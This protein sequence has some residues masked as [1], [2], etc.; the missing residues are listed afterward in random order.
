MYA[1]IRI[2]GSVGLRGDLEQTLR[3]LRLNR[4]NHCVLLKKDE[5]SEG[6]LR[7]VVGFITWGE[8]SNDTLK[9]LVAKRGRLPGD[10]R[11]DEKAAKAA[12]EAILKHKNM[13]EAVIKPVFRLSPP[14]KGIKSVRL[15]FPKGDSGY[16]GDKINELL[17]KMI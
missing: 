6:M 9:K 16:R 13:K 11:L 17:E 10:V 3:Y 4:V 1:A 12:A 5:K 2:R 15:P 8:I 7:K 14:R